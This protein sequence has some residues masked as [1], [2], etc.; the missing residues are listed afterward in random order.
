MKLGGDAEADRISGQ[1]WSDFTG[2]NAWLAQH[3]W[4]HYLFGGADENYLKEVGW[5]IIKVGHSR[6]K[7]IFR[8]PPSTGWRMYSRMNTSTTELS[9]LPPVTRP[10]NLLISTRLSAVLHINKWL[11]SYSSLFSKDT[12][13]LAKRTCLSSK[14]STPPMPRWILERILD[15]GVKFRNGRLMRIIRLIHT[16]TSRISGVFTLVVPLPAGTENPLPERRSPMR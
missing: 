11:F 6:T 13:Q 2:S 10:N 15:D 16:D 3:V 12:P 9:S 5:P 1:Q 7:L 8:V 14:K 4:D